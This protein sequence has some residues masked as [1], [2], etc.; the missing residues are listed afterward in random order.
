MNRISKTKDLRQKLLD[1][2]IL[3]SFPKVEFHRHLEGT[4]SIE[5]L[6]EISIKNGLDIP[7][8]YEVFKK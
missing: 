8:D 6:F 7:K 5:K 4:F 2:S 1:K 3:K